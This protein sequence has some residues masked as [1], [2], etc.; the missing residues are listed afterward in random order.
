MGKKQTSKGSPPSKKPA[1]KKGETKTSDHNY[2]AC[3]PITATRAKRSLV[4]MMMESSVKS[5][6][7][8]SV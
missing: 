6:S 4:M 1:T 7:S 2:S 5:A 3:D 8:G